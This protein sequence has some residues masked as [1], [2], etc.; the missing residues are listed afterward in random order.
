MLKLIIGLIFKDD[1]ILQ[2][3]ESILSKK[4]SEVDFQSQTLPFTHTNYYQKE[5][6]TD[7]KRKFISFKKLICPEKLYKI[8]I[9]TNNIERKLS[10]AGNRTINIDPGY[11]DLSKLVLFSTKNYGHRIYIGRGIYAE[12]TLIFRDKSFKHLDWTYPDYKTSEY[13]SIFSHIR[14][15]YAQQIKLK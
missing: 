4:F 2:K 8:K 7:L 1:G 3:A 12:V 11:L 10:S 13:I 5:F 6:G 15:I 9:L 14:Q